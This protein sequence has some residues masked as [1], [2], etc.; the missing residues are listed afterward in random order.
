MVTDL[1]TLKVKL[2]PF[3]LPNRSGEKGTCDE[4]EAAPFRLLDLDA[5]WGL[6][7][8]RRIRLSA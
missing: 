4:E 6:D 5:W 1:L 7:Q 8:R 2:Q 3:S